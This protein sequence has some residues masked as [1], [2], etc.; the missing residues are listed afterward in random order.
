VAIDRWAVWRTQQIQE[1]VIEAYRS[2]Q[3]HLIYQKVH[4]FCSV[5]L[6]GFYLDVLKDRMYTMRSDSPSRR[7]AQ[8]AMFWIAEAMT[9]W[10]A[11]IL[12]FTSDEIWG[13]MPG[14]RGESVFLQT[15]LALPEG[16]A[17]QPALDWDSMLR[18]RG[19]VTRE[20]EKLRNNGA[21]GAPLDAEIDLYCAPPVFDLLSKFGEELRFVFITSAA[22][23]HPLGEKPADAVAGDADEGAAWIVARP[24]EAVKC[25]RC[26]HRR[27][28]VGSH[29]KHPE[30]CGRCVSNV[31]G[32][33]ETRKYV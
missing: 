16:A 12:S 17:Q 30:L 10:L 9:R 27:P 28:D 29:A 22:R 24:T 4:N 26:W 25:K 7:S 3:F 33:G 2:Y 15:W 5:D 21:I 31:E 32:P 6:G 20:L 23:V 8:T 1:E 18:V 11:P 13:F 19:A 14:Q